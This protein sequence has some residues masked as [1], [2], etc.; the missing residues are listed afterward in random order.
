MGGLERRRVAGSGRGVGNRLRL[1][2][3]VVEI[4]EMLAMPAI[5][6]VPFQLK[7]GHLSGKFGKEL[8]S[9]NDFADSKISNKKGMKERKCK[10]MKVFL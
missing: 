3:V 9:R 8:I 1:V 10:F 4:V 5:G 6:I 2:A 7:K